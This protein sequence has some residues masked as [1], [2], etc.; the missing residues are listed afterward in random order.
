M[1]L[2]SADGHLVL[3]IYADKLEGHPLY[4]IHVH[5]ESRHWFAHVERA[6]NSYVAELGYYTTVGR[7]TRVAVSAATV[8]PPDAVAPEA[9]DGF[10]HHPV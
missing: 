5:P 6:G 4:E 10:R 3:R 2:K 9:E 7:W 8:T 1:N